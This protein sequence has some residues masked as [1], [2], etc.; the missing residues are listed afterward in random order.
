LIDIVSNYVPD[1]IVFGH[2]DLIDNKTIEFIKKIIQ[3]LKCVS[4]FLIEW[5]VNGNLIKIDL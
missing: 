1:L 5:M 4:G 3:I 2:A